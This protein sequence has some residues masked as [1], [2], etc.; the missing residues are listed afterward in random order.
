[1]EK[2]IT[3]KKSVISNQVNVRNAHVAL[4]HTVQEEKKERESQRAH[5]ITNHNARIMKWCVV[6]N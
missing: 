4:A 3:I 2:E 6:Y 5:G 1:M